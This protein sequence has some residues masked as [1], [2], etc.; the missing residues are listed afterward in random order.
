MSLLRLSPSLL[1]AGF[2][3]ATLISCGSDEAGEE[4]HNWNVLVVTMDTTRPDWLGCYGSDVATP[5]IDQVARDGARFERCVSTAG[6]TPMSHASILTGQNNYTHGMRVFHSSEISHTMKEEV[7]SLPEILKRQRGYSTAAMLSAYVVSEIYNLHQGF[8]KFLHGVDLDEINAEKQNKHKVFF[9][10]SG[11]TTTQ[12]RADRTVNDAIGWLDAQKEADKPWCMWMHLFDVHDYTIVPPDEYIAELGATF[13]GTTDKAP[14]GMVSHQLRHDLY[15]PEM[16]YM[17]SQIGRVLDWLREN[18]QYDETI[19]VL[20]ADHGQGLLDGLERHGWAKHR[21]L[22]DWSIRVPLIV[23]IPGQK[24]Q[25]VIST[26]V[27]TTDIVPTVLHALGVGA[28]QDMD[29]ASALALIQGQEDS[30]ARIAYADALN[31]FDDHAPAQGRLP[32]GQHDNLYCATD[33]TWK[34]V[35]HNQNPGAGELFDLSSDPLE[36][37]NL[38]RL[39]HPEAERL[40]AFLDAEK[41]FRVDKPRAGEGSTADAAALEGMGYGGG[42]DDE[43]D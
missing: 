36:E 10:R 28:E 6:I 22:Y 35:W 7:D 39:D 12:R 8:D 20:T 13:P 1:V 5:N 19:V 43:D 2:G 29:G 24:S 9:D 42:G 26:Q 27:R 11:K 23:K 40:K 15:G 4:S 33:G 18:D 25:T 38:F 3:A 31:L 30:E 17:D 32:K 21:L 16:T 37:H 41:A 14:K 34:L